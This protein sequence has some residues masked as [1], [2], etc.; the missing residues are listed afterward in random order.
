ME[1]NTEILLKQAIEKLDESNE[2]LENQFK[3]FQ[4]SE[5]ELEKEVEQIQKSQNKRQESITEIKSREFTELTFDI[6]FDLFK[7]ADELLENVSQ[8]RVGQ[9]LNFKLLQLYNR[10]VDYRKKM[11]KG[12]A[13]VKNE[14]RLDAIQIRKDLKRNFNSNYVKIRSDKTKKRLKDF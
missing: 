12:L 11:V 14:N 10:V 13:I 7:V 8:G 9:N 6:V 4:K 5:K 1:R 3:K 2:K